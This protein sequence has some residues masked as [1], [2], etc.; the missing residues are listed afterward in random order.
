MALNY[1]EFLAVFFVYKFF[2]KFFLQ[3]LLQ[4]FPYSVVVE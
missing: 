3:V 4:G 2:Y 1:R